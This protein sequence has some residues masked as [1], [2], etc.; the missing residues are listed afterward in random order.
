MA[1]KAGVLRSPMESQRR[2]SFY[3]F[4]APWLLGF[5]LV[6]LTPIVWGF[7]ISL[8][9]RTAFPV[10]V[11]FIGFANYLKALQDPDI[12]RSFWVS[13]V[14]TMG[15]TAIA[16]LGGFLF[17]LLLDRSLPGRG[18]F[19]TM[20]Y[21]PYMIPAVAAGWIFRLFLERDTGFLNIVLRTLG[22]AHSDTAWLQ[23]FPM[24]SIL[25]MSLWQAG[26][27]MIIFLGALSTVPKELY[28]VATIDGAGYFRRLRHI[29]LPLIS[30]F[31]FFQLVMSTIYGMQAFLQPY[32]LNPRPFRGNWIMT[33]N[34]PD[35][36]FLMMSRSYYIIIGQRKFAYGLAML[37]IL[38]AVIL[39]I[40]LI[41]V[42]SSRLWVFSETDERS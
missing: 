3:F 9:N 27:S 37:W 6:Q 15:N 25:L 11:K 23:A 41:F 35:E 20:L 19:R 32:L 1:R 10:A 13:F 42:K 2:R 21:F 22:I 14:Y 34:P 33:N 30:P 4:I 36:T 39:V 8:T 38:F 12:L 28:E 5:V 7:F 26:W 18:F 29:M 31:V 40:T 17:A 24:G 16:V